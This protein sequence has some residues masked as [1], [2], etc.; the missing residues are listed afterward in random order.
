MILPKK[1]YLKKKSDKN[2]NTKE[3]K[4]LEAVEKKL[5]KI[6]LNMEKFKFVDYVYY[7]DHPRKL[8][9]RNFIAGISRGFG[10]GVGFTLLGALIIYILNIIVKWNIPVLGNFIT[11][12]VRIVESNLGRSGGKIDG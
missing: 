6:A 1:Y 2:I 10:I 12:I 5:D 4:P 8:F 3:G 11:E 9:Y 7:L